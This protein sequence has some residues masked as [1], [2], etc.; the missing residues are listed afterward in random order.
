[1]KCNISLFFLFLSFL[2]VV[3]STLDKYFFTYNNHATLSIYYLFIYLFG[4]GELS[5]DGAIWMGLMLLV[6]ILTVPLRAQSEAV[7]MLRVWHILISYSQCSTLIYLASV[8]PA[9]IIISFTFPFSWQTLISQGKRL[10]LG[11]KAFFAIWSQN[12]EQVKS[13]SKQ[14]LIN[15]WTLNVLAQLKW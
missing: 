13:T 12:N 3:Y 8:F 4:G 10:R 9:Q 2:F 5:H 14:T 1:M 15:I 7:I 11:R 6:N